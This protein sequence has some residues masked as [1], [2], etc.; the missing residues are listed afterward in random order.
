MEEVDRLP[1]SSP[2]TLASVFLDVVCACALCPSAVSLPLLDGRHSDISCLVSKDVEEFP[3]E[4]KK[5][6]FSPELKERSPSLEREAATLTT[7]PPGAPSMAPRVACWLGMPGVF[8]VILV[9][10]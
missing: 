4:K 9:V 6:T 2:G 3:W 5:K 1:A 8:L 10:L 7:A